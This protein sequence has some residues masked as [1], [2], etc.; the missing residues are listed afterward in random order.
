MDNKRDSARERNKNFATQRRSQR[1][2][3]RRFDFAPTRRR[4]IE[5]H[6]RHIGAADSDDFSRWLIA[7]VWHNQK[8]SDPLCALANAAVRMG[9]RLTEAEARATPDE[10]AA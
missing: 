6:A 2:Y 8:S 5:R 7:W 4:E 9:G 10:P 1:K 3:R